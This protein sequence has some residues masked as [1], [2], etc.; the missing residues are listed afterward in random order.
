MMPSSDGIAITIIIWTTPA[1]L[2]APSQC[3]VPN[4]EVPLYDPSP[5]DEDLAINTVSFNANDFGVHRQVSPLAQAPL[6]FRA[7]PADQDK[8]DDLH[9]C[10]GLNVQEIAHEP[11][12]DRLG[13]LRPVVSLIAQQTAKAL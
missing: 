8:N 1:G 9:L 11:G 3:R 2:Q 12:G 7:D 13:K 6:N 5:C 4:R 10:D